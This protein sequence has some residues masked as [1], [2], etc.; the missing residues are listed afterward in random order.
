MNHVTLKSGEQVP[1]LGQGTWRM[2]EA[3]NRRADEVRALRAGLDLGLTLIDTAEMYGSGSSEEAV[4]EAVGDRRSEVFL[5]SKVL[6][7]NA[8]VAGTIKACEASLKR[9]RTDRLDLYLLHWRGSHPLADTVAAFERLRGEGKIRYWGVSNFDVEDMIE[10]EEVEGGSHC[11]VNQVLY[12]IGV[13]GPEWKL[14]PMCIEQRVTVM[15]YTPLG[16][17]DLLDK[18][19]VK[20]MARRHDT[21]PAAIALAWVM[22][23]PGTVAIP[24]A[25]NVEHVRD[26]ARALEV[27]LSPDDLKELDK[28]FQPPQRKSPLAIL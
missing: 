26:N 16:Q 27:M 2:G 21:T 7:Q 28:T 12:N 3:R 13:R 5:V 24:K 14:L 17:G 9:L 8:S 4:A 20:A 10:L 6:P 23:Q 19:A 22:R 15:A 18:P 11:A 25:A 1:A